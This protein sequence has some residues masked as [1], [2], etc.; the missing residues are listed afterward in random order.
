MQNYSKCSKTDGKREKSR[1]S[2]FKGAEQL[3]RSE[4]K[5]NLNDL[6]IFEP[7]IVRDFLNEESTTGACITKKSVCSYFKQIYV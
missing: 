1:L 6:F 4:Y 2:T 7:S 5:Q 3:I